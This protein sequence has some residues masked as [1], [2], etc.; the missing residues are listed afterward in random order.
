MSAMTSQNTNNSTVCSTGWYQSKHQISAS[1]ALC[2][3][4]PPVTGGIPSQRTSNAESVSMS[5]RHHVQVLT[6]FQ[7]SRTYSDIWYKKTIKTQSKFHIRVTEAAWESW[8]L[9]PCAISHV[10]TLKS[11]ASPSNNLYRLCGGFLSIFFSYFFYCIT[12]PV[13][14]IWCV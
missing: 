12:G 3:G 2:E 5:W 8:L 4:I 11:H 1:L 14:R 7:N 10:M 13:C 9:D 6:P